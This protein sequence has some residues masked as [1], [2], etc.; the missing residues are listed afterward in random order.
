M[1]CMYFAVVLCTG[2]APNCYYYYEEIRFKGFPRDINMKESI[3]SER[4]EPYSRKECEV[5]VP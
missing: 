3:I 1:V 2:L 4:V 5:I